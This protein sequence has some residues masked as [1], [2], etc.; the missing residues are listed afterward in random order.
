MELDL[1]NLE[2]AV[3]RSIV[4]GVDRREAWRKLADADGLSS[5]LAEEVDLEVRAGARGTIRLA[6]DD[7]RLVEVEEVESMRRLSLL[8]R[9]P[10]GEPSLVEI[11]LDDTEHGTQLTVIEMPTLA[12]RVLAASIESQSHAGRGPTMLAAL[13]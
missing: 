12:L 5:W 2:Q 3:R 13:V 11:T 7:I 4:L 8:W 10:D 6:G 1:G 9:E